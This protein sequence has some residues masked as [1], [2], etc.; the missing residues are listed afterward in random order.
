MCPTDCAWRYAVFRIPLWLGIVLYICV[1]GPTVLAVTSIF[2]VCFRKTLVAGI[3]C[4]F[5]GVLLSLPWPI[6]LWLFGAFDAGDTKL[7]EFTW[8]SLLMVG[9][10]VVCVLMIVVGAV[11]RDEKL[12]RKRN[13]LATSA[14][15]SP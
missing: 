5:V 12:R 6:F 13:G 7:I 11:R 14:S 8:P 1:Y 2:L 9:P 10:P 3:V 15:L 4:G